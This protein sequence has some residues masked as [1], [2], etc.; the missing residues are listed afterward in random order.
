MVTQTRFAVITIMVTTQI[1]QKQGLTLFTTVFPPEQQLL[2]GA[3]KIHA[4]QSQGCH[5]LIRYF[6]PHPLQFLSHLIFIVSYEICVIIIIHV[7]LMRKVI[8][9]RLGKGQTDQRGNSYYVTWRGGCIIIIKSLT[10]KP[11]CTRTG[12]VLFYLPLTTAR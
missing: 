3:Q 5:L 11:L 1:L 10:E 4:D 12:S 8:L 6:M 9:S 7:L 2:G